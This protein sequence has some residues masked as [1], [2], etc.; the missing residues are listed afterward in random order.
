MAFSEGIGLNFVLVIWL[1]KII[2]ALYNFNYIK[3]V[4][5][6]T[7]FVLKESTMYTIVRT[8]CSLHGQMYNKICSLFILKS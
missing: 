2:F 7:C 8:K 5:L 3:I 4:K 6:W 1:V